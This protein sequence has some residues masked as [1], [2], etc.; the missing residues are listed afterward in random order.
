MMCKKKATFSRFWPLASFLVRVARR[1]TAFRSYHRG[2]NHHTDKGE[3]ND[4]VMHIEFPQA[5]SVN[6]T[7]GIHRR[8]R[9]NLQ[10]D[11]AVMLR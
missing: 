3:G 11:E 10:C 9:K 2:G 8:D 1:L 7:H 4:E 6:R 5:A